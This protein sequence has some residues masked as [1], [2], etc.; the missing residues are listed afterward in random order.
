MTVK[1]SFILIRDSDIVARI[2]GEEFVVLLTNT[3]KDAAFKV[4]DIMR[5]FTQHQVI[6]TDDA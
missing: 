5:T 3:A 1:Q 6:K 2:G 4:A